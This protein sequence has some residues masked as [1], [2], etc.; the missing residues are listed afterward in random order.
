MSPHSFPPFPVGL[1]GRRHELGALTAFL[2]RSPGGTRIALVG[3]GGSGKSMLACA[4]GYRVRSSFPGGIHW[5]RS[6]PWD[7][8]TIGE[9]LAMRF[10]TARE[11]TRLMPALREALSARGHTFIVL[12]NHENDRAACAVL[13]ALDGCAVTWVVT[14]RRCLLGGVSVF[15][16]VAPLGTTGKA[17]FPRVKRL[18]SLLR[19]SPLA[20]GI[21]E[22]IVRSGAAGVRALEAWLIERG[23]ERVRVV[24]HEDAL[25]EVELLVAW[26]WERLTAEQRRILAVLAHTGG[27]H[28]DATSLFALARVRAGAYGARALAA[29]LRWNLVQTPWP[30]RY[31][32]H[33]VVRYA[34][35]KRTRLEARRFATYYL[36][37]L[38]R[39]PERLEL[40]QT[41]FYAAMDYAHAQSSV[42]WSLRIERILA[43]LEA[44]P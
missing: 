26:A 10:G 12:D 25:P 34:V 29:L 7:A 19:H 40:E 9:M 28:V 18:T 14:A 39:A 32:L 41:H 43:H 21:A 33:A 44:G 5:F 37:L 4:L 30:G 11:R 15:P 20:L 36:A 2:A 27:D 17:A 16:V 42:T 23:I 3:G 31:A 35:A 1:K 24:E 8:R 22:G 6:G 38:A 13:N